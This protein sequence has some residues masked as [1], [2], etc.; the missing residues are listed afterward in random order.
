M[1]ISKS[2]PRSPGSCV[3]MPP[4]LMSGP[5]PGMSVPQ[6]GLRATFSGE[7]RVFNRTSG[8]GPGK[9]C[10]MSR[11]IDCGRQGWSARLLP[12]NPSVLPRFGDGRRRDRTGRHTAWVPWSVRVR[13]F[14]MHTFWQHGSVDRDRVHCRGRC[15]ACARRSDACSL[16][17]TSGINPSVLHAGTD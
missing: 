17:S 16:A 3:R 7:P 2:N 15:R 5:Q 12:E 4:R 6:S 8:K 1:R 9:R 10:T 14:Q 11:W 13:S